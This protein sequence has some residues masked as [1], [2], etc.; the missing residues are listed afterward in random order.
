MSSIYKQTIIPALSLFTSLGTLVCCALPA[1]LVTLGLG[2]ALAGIV[3]DIPGLIWLSEHKPLVFGVA[4]I[5]LALASFMQWRARH[6]PCPADPLEAK[7]CKRM[8]SVS[9]GILAF[10]IVIY[11]IG[12]FFAF[13][14]VHIFY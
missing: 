9:L 11:T 2:A 12:F 13:I 4:G 10:S 3:S 6:M 1:L 5:L 14:A 8:R 7:A